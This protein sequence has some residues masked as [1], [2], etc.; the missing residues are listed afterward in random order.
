LK[1]KHKGSML[2]ESLTAL[3]ISLL[4]VFTLTYCVNEQFKLLQTWEEKVN[5]DKII[6]LHLK[7]ENVPDILVVKGKKYFFRQRDDLYQVKVNNS[8]YQIKK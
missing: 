5:A 8:V 1:L 4:V 6:L 3:A 2:L 7:N